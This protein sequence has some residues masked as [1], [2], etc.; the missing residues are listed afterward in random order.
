MPGASFLTRNEVGHISVAWKINPDE[1]IIM[2]K[3]TIRELLKAGAHFGD[4]IR[5]L[6]GNGH[7]LSSFSNTFSYMTD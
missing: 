7:N 4:F 2:S 1:E 6:Y 3:V 5:S